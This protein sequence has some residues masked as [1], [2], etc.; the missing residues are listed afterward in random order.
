ME[1]ERQGKADFKHVIKSIPSMSSFNSKLSTKTETNL[2]TSI[3][4]NWEVDFAVPFV[5]R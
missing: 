3:A 1:E 4:W 2:A 5:V